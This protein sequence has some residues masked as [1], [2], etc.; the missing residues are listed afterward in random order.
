ME[1][2]NTT[3]STLSE[4]DKK[5]ARAERFGME[6]KENHSINVHLIINTH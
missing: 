1:N 2:T 6:Y 4:M 5:K 3:S